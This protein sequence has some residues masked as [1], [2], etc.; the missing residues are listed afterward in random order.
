M[1]RKPFLYVIKDPTWCRI[2]YEFYGTKVRLKREA[3]IKLE[4]LELKLILEG[5][6]KESSFE[7]EFGFIILKSEF[8]EEVRKEIE[9]IIL[10]PNNWE[11]SQA[12]NKR[13]EKSE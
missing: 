5:I 9:T 8:L 6:V 13:R 1:N 7:S 11:V 2:V 4:E 12:F 3:L 10:D